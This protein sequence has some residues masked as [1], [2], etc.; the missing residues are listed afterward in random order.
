MLLVNKW[1]RFSPR[2]SLSTNIGLK[3]EA[4]NTRKLQP[5]TRLEQIVMKKEAVVEIDEEERPDHVPD[6]CIPFLSNSRKLRDW[7]TMMSLMTMKMIPTKVVRPS[8]IGQ[9]NQYWGLFYLR[10]SQ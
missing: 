3:E 2:L 8:R 10:P 1:Y 6:V 5:T 7:T 4:E 9:L